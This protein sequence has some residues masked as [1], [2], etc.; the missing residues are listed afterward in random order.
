MINTIVLVGRLTAD[1][2]VRY[3]QSGIAV[4][5]L[6]V[7]VDRNFKNAQGEKE[8][9]FINAVA[10]R[11]AAELIGQYASKGN[12]IGLR[13]SLQV[14]KYTDKDGNNRTAYEVVVEDFQFLEPKRDGSAGGS[15]PRPGP[16]PTPPP[17]GASPYQDNMPPEPPPDN[18]MDDDLPF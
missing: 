9:D 10:W 12:M 17:P 7:A 13:G 5:R 2:D 8:T 11:K 18:F 1:P 4:A 3:T 14:R 6:S 15:G 16:K